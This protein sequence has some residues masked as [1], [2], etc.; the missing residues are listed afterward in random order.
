MMSAATLLGTSSQT[1]VSGT[2]VKTLNWEVRDESYSD[3]FN[4][5]SSGWQ[6]GPTPSYSLTYAN[7]T[8]VGRED[9][10]WDSDAIKITVKV[11]LDAITTGN[12]LGEVGVSFNYW[13]EGFDQDPTTGD[14]RSLWSFSIYGD[15][16]YRVQD[17]SW[18]KWTYQD[19]FS[20][21]DFGFPAYT[22]KP[23]PK[24]KPLP[25]EK[26]AFGHDTGPDIFL[27]NTAT[28]TA[29]LQDTNSD[30]IDDTWI[31][32]MEGN[33]NASLPAGRW[34]F[35]LRIVDSEYQWIESGYFAWDSDQAPWRDLWLDAPFEE[36]E[37]FGFGDGYT[38]QQRSNTGE[39]LLVVDREVPMQFQYNITSFTGLDTVIWKLDLPYSYNQ[40]GVE[41]FYDREVFSYQLLEL[42]HDF[43]TKY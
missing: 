30:G 38:A 3:D 32:F 29:S 21:S 39:P 12:D 7:D 20:Y 24:N 18:E 36:F 9:T 10:V 22:E 8:P 16:S 2:S 17:N 14:R 23:V 1:A 34:N 13:E 4:W 19:N 6:F 28:R 5:T 33:F 35:N 37:Y 11:P 42:S 40:S 27:W 31:I 41:Q 15:Y 25:A 26:P 43:R